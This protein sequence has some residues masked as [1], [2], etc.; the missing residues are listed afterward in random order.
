M[1]HQLK[2]ETVNCFFAGPTGLKK[3]RAREKNLA[4][5]PQPRFAVPLSLHYSYHV[6]FVLGSFTCSR[7]SS[8]PIA[9]GCPPLQH[10]A[11]RGGVLQTTAL[12]PQPSQHRGDMPARSKRTTW[13]KHCWKSRV[14]WSRECFLSSRLFFLSFWKLEA[15]RI[16]GELCIAVPGTYDT[17]TELCQVFRGGC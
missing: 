13:R 1:F 11:A 14:T 10:H 7:W 4:P 8:G 5:Y 2:L 12:S 9:A 17:Y 3:K 16:L 15:S 6:F